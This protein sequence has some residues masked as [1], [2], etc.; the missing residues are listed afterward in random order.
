VAVSDGQVHAAEQVDLPA[1]DLVSL[2][3]EAVVLRTTSGAVYR[4]VLM[5]GWGQFYNRQAVK[6][7]LFVGSEVVAAGLAVTFHL[8]GAHYQSQYDKMGAGTPQSKVDAKIDQA[9][10]NFSRRNWALI[11]LAVVH[12]ANILDAFVNGRTY[13]SASVGS[14]AGA[15]SFVW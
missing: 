12:A 10:T 6:G 15:G 1:A 7:G 3:S 14:G 13:N 4:S 5:P 11:A 9:E 8:L 2:S